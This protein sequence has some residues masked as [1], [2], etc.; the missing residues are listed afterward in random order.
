MDRFTVRGSNSVAA[1]IDAI[2]VSGNPTTLVDRFPTTVTTTVARGDSNKSVYALTSDQFGTKSVSK[3]GGTDGVR[4]ESLDPA[5]FVVD[6]KSGK[7]TTVSE[8]I[9]QLRI[10]AGSINKVFT[11]TVTA[12][13]KATSLALDTSNVTKAMRGGSVANNASIKVNVLDQNG[14]PM[15]NSGAALTFELVSGESVVSYKP[16]DIT[17]SYRFSAPVDERVTLVGKQDR[18]AYFKVT[19]DKTGSTYIMVSVTVSATNSN[20]AQYAFEGVKDF[21]IEK[22]FTNATGSEPTTISVYG[23][24]A[25]GFKVSSG[26]FW[27]VSFYPKT[28]NWFA[29][30]PCLRFYLCFPLQIKLYYLVNAVLI[31]TGTS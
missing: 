30:I 23:V 4:F 18:T 1:N 27:A 13:P 9:G 11:I 16:V 31:T 2:T 3:N 24:T 25:D 29:P 22:V 26:S 19:S 8:G 7:I 14:N 10:I 12:V 5:V 17:T 6:S 15:S 28:G 21:D 20:I